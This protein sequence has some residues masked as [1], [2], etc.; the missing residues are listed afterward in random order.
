MRQ[1]FVTTSLETGGAQR[2][3][4]EIIQHSNHL[5]EDILVIAL[6]GSGRY[7]VEFDEIGVKNFS[8][9]I[10]SPVIGIFNFFR[11]IFLVRDFK[12]TVIQGWMYHGNLMAYLYSRFLSKDINV[13]WGIRQ[14]LYDIS[15]EKLFTRLII[16]IS[17]LLS[18]KIHKIIYNSKLSMKQHEKFGF[19][20]TQSIFIAN[21]FDIEKLKFSE[22]KR[23]RIRKAFSISEDSFVIGY[24]GRNHPMKNISLLFDIAFDVLKQKP[25]IVFVIVGEGISSKFFDNKKVPK[26]ILDR[27]IILGLRTDV[28]DLLNSFD[29]LCLTSKWGEGFPNVIGEAMCLSVPCVSSDVGDSKDIINGLGWIVSKNNSKDE[30]IKYINEASKIDKNTYMQLKSSCRKEI[31]NKYH[32]KNISYDY[33]K[34]YG[35]DGI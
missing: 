5:A 18:K 17:A 26:E 34:L 30:Y 8:I 14:T 16:N 12:P 11:S 9:N 6:L 33:M 22:E 31:K 25:E 32:I 15:K 35:V 2:A 1:L 19:S 10:T 21:G 20:E 23:K 3:L 27:L 13:F 24:V 4:F 28:P 7:S 29:L